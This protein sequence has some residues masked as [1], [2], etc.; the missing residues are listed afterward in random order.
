MC[1][2]GSYAT[3]SELVNLVETFEKVLQRHNLRIEVNSEL[4]RLC[5]QIYE[6]Y[7]RYVQHRVMDNENMRNALVDVLGAWE[8]FKRIVNLDSLVDFEAFVPHLELLCKCNKNN[9][10]IQ[11]IAR[12][13]CNDTAN[14]VFE[15]L[16]AFYI[17]Q[18]GGENIM[19]DDPV[20]SRGDNPDILVTFEGER[21][22][23]ACKTLYTTSVNTIVERIRE[24]I[25]Q[26]IVAGVD[27]GCVVLNFSNT[28]GG[29]LEL[30]ERLRQC[31]SINEI[32]VVLTKSFNEKNSEIQ[33]FIKKDP[34]RDNNVIPGYLGFY[35]TTYIENSRPMLISA[36]NSA[37][38]SDQEIPAEDMEIFNR[39][40]DRGVH[41][42][43]YCHIH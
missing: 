31:Y 28:L 20:R 22:G 15:L 21:W 23:F 8:L 12:S 24:G 3:L 35:Q 13:Q 41:A 16:M 19:L 9:S 1:Q 7:D 17:L 36:L 27:K 29:D 37:N 39:I 42:K 11:N 5:L 25:D 40:N 4:E 38:L 34:F 32:I 6:V 10:I 14:K 43:F 18:A 26:I 2:R 30:D 33:N